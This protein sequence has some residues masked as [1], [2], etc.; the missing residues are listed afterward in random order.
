M[1]DWQQWRNTL[2]LHWGRASSMITFVKTYQTKQLK[3]VPFMLCKLYQ[4][5]WFK[6]KEKS[7]HQES[8]LHAL[9]ISYGGIPGPAFWCVSGLWCPP[10]HIWPRNYLP[11]KS[12]LPS[13]GGEGVAIP[14]D[15]S[16]DRLLQFH[17]KFPALSS[18][19][20]LIKACDSALRV[21]TQDSC[22]S[23][24]ARN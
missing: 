14:L 10:C 16:A 19:P 12:L 22:P 13:L 5:S 21:A 11:R 23:S 18:T 4:E 24:L 8:N 20:H 15:S 7:D 17:G 3:W 6:M 1:R 9:L 2:K